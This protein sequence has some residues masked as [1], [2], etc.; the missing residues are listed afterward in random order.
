MRISTV[1]SNSANG[2][3]KDRSSVIEA[4]SC[5][6]NKLNTFTFRLR[7]VSWC[8]TPSCLSL[9]ETSSVLIYVYLFALCY[10]ST[11]QGKKGTGISSA[12][13]HEYDD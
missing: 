11:F 5:A 8:S 10:I 2:A 4:P 7:I 1:C 3:P 9:K 6:E 13:V 12:F